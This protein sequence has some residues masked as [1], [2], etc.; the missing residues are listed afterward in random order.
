[1]IALLKAGDGTAQAAVRPFAAAPAREQSTEAETAPVERPPTPPM[2]HTPAPPPAIARDDPRLA[3]LERQVDELTARLQSAAL[4]A[5]AREAD[6]FSR[7]ERTGREQADTRAEERL[8]TLAAAL[9]GAQATLAGQIEKLEVLALEVAQTA[10][11]S[12]FGQNNRYGDMAADSVHHQLRQID[13]ALVIRVRIPAEDFGDPQALAELA[14]RLP[15]V[16]LH[17]DPALAHGQCTID[18]KLGRIEAGI[19]EQWPRLSRLLDSMAGNGDT[20]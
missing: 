18:L 8:Q 7:G 5:E 14:A 16:E 9:D 17:A 12:I 4:A 19:A 20:P 10:L 13:S 15:D 3:Q 1:M 11:A 2:E 6:A